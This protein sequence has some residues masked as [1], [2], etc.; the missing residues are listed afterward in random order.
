[1]MDP[2]VK[3]AVGFCYRMWPVD[4]IYTWIANIWDDDS[5]ET[6]LE[7]GEDNSRKSGN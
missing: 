3:R 1:M 4:E 2:T 6:M 7:D 5:E